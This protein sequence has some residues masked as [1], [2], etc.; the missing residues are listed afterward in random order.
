MSAEPFL[1][2]ALNGEPLTLHQGSPLRLI[3]PGL[4]R[5]RQRQVAL[6]DSRSAGRVPRQVPGALVPHAA[7]RDDRRRD[8][9]G[10]DRRHAHEPEVVHRARHARTAA[11][12]KVLGVVL[13]DGTP[14]KSVEVKVDDG[15]WQPATHRSGDDE[16]Q[17]LVEV[18]QLHVERRHAGRTH[19]R[20]ARHRRDRP[21]AADRE[22]SR[23]QEVVPR[24]QLA[25]AA[26]D[27]GAA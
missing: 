24:G 6:G 21:R 8:E 12:Y 2:W 9:V 4:V 10:R 15:P 1:A 20:L 16:G 26:Q 14:I 27:H 7:R 17:V 23:E 11:R 25:G 18:L 3:V 13:N 5:R 19:D 22:G